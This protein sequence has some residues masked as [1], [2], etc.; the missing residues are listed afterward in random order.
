VA[1]PVEDDELVRWGRVAR[2]ATHGRRSGLQRATSVGFIAEGDGS[3]LVAA[4]DPETDWALNLRA[5]PRCL[6]T[7][8]EHEAAYRAE[9]LDDAERSAAVQALILRY[10]TPSERLGGGPAFRLRLLPR[11]SV[12]PVRTRGAPDR[13]PG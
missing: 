2:L 9:E 1:G 7:I 5:D 6:V 3:L 12:G 11:E 13:R 8:G 10:G 4:A